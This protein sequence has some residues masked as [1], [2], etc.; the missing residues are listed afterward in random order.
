MINKYNET[1]ITIGK[2]LR[3]VR[4][5]KKLTQEQLAQII[6][7][8]DRAKISK[9][10]NAQADFMISKILQICSALEIDLSELLKPVDD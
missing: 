10:E 4:N 8:M 6:P 2:N 7:K 9:I 5:S 3:K 1:Y